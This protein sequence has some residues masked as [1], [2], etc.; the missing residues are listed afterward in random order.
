MNVKL[1]NIS[2][3]PELIG[4]DHFWLICNYKLQIYLPGDKYSK[5]TKIVGASLHNPMTGYYHL[6]NFYNYYSNA[7]GR[8]DIII[9]LPIYDEYGFT[10]K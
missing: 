3:K 6:V 7:S 10:L 1:I 5:L 2:D 9:N 4:L 8:L